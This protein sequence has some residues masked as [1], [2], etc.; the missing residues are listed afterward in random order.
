MMGSSF[1]RVAI[2]G[3]AI[4]GGAS[5]AAAATISEGSFAG[6]DFSGTAMAPTAIAGGFDTVTGTIGGGDNDILA[7]TGMATGAQQVTLSFAAPGGIGWSYI[8]GGSVLYSTQPFR[9]DWDG[10]FAGSFATALWSPTSSVT[11]N[12]GAGFAG[13]LYLALYS[14]GDISSYSISA[15]GNAAPAAVPLPAAGLLL[16]GAVAGVGALRRRGKRAAA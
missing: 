2:L 8:S 3:L 15:P 10:T 12:L 5:T 6:G 14:W 13:S 4:A 11:I 9:W 1:A 16:G 7:F